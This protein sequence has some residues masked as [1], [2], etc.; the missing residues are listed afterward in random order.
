MEKNTEDRDNKQQLRVNLKKRRNITYLHKLA[1]QN[2]STDFLIQDDRK[3]PSVLVKLHEFR[4]DVTHKACLFL[5]KDTR[6]ES[7]AIIR[8]SVIF[9]H[10]LSR[11]ST[12]CV[13][14]L[15][16]LS[17]Q[18]NIRYFYINICDLKQ[19]MHAEA[20]SCLRYALKTLSLGTDADIS[21]RFKTLF[22]ENWFYF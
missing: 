12:I 17:C 16:Q 3:Y 5:V 20:Y 4:L 11:L 18:G 8:P 7:P 6:Y 14:G 9:R 1:G 2:Q 15:Q 13:C 19:E 10:N 21:V 22:S